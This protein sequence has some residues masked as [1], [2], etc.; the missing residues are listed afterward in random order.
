MKRVVDLDTMLFSV[1]LEQFFPLEAS[2]D[3]SGLLLL[4]DLLSLKG[5]VLDYDGFVLPSSPYLVLDLFLLFGGLLYRGQDASFSSGYFNELVFLGLFY[6]HLSPSFLALVLLLL[7]LS[8]CK[9]TLFPSLSW[10]RIDYLCLLLDRRHSS[11]WLTLSLRVRIR[12]F[13]A[14][15][16]PLKISDIALKRSERISF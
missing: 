10:S 1:S 12:L 7:A 15:V 16:P 4:S 13:T 6:D 8:A 2:I 9:T 11:W 5:L 3:L 14:K